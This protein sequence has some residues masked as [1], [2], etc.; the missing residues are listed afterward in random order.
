VKIVVRDP[1][2][3]P[4][5]TRFEA[6]LPPD[7][8][9][10]WCDPADPDAVLAE[11]ADA[12]VFVGSRFDAAMAAAAPH[13]RLVHAAAAGTDKIDFGALGPDTSVANTFHHEQSI[14]EYV[15]ATAV[16]MRRQFLAQDRALRAGRWATSV[17]DRTIAQPRA[18][19]GARVGFV[20]FGHI[21]RCSWNLL[22]PFGVDGVAVTGSGTLDAAAHGLV[23]AAATDR[24]PQLMTEADVVVVSAPL[25]E[26][27]AGMVGAAEL[28]ALGPDGVLINVGRGPLV[29]AADLFAA[30]SSGRLGAAAIDVWYDYPDASGHG[31]PSTL[32]FS[33]LPNLLMTPHSSGVTQHTFTGRADDVAANIGRL[34]RGEPLRN[35]VSR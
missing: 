2:L 11:L 20:G 3:L 25:S 5:R 27:T 7:A 19:H 8:A 16:L 35:V 18:L 28:D 13:L 23:W 31:Q 14:A 1:N 10:V 32:P 6:A 17:Y 9:A 4:H 33:A 21:G 15:V 24:L 34:A 29:V 30:L 22:R 12:E 26:R